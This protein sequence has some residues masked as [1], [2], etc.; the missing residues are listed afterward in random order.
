MSF[1]R[2]GLASG[3]RAPQRMV[4]AE[5]LQDTQGQRPAWF[6]YAEEMASGGGITRRHWI[7]AAIVLV[8]GIVTLD[9]FFAGTTLITPIDDNFQ[10]A[11][12]ALGA[13]A[14]FVAA[15]WFWL[16]NPNSER[17]V[18]ATIALLIGAPLFGAIWGYSVVWRFADHL[19]F[20]ASGAEWATADYPVESFSQPSRKG[21]LFTSYTASIDPFGAGSARVPV[22]EEQ[23]YEFSGRDDV[24]ITVDQRRAPDGAIEIK[25]KGSIGLTAPDAARLHTCGAFSR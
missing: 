7:M 6:K 8:F 25:T 15:F 3:E 12:V 17:G 18:R 5:P 11:G 23:Y 1:G 21:R 22:T 4:H 2:K 16:T 20:G 19:E 24:C 10:T 14:A 13:T 9:T